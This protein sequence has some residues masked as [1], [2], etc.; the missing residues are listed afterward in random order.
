MV[1]SVTRGPTH[2]A[3]AMA[4]ASVAAP[5]RGCGRAPPVPAGQVAA[6]L[7]AHADAWDKAIV[8]KDRIAI[9]ANMADD[10]RH[11]D[12]SGHVESRAS[13][14]D[15]LV[16]PDLRIDPY[17]VEE[18]DVRIYGRVALVSGRTRMTGTYRGKPFGSHYRFIDIYV[19]SD[20]QWKIVSV[21]ISRLPS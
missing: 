7:A 17:T 14:V 6:Q 15:G 9:E 12:G 21:Q 5:L 19:Q 20:R 1:E 16:S 2:S 4:A 3:L 11:I 8:R 10:F 13:F 18:F